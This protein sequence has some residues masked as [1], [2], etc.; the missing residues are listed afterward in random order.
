[1][2]CVRLRSVARTI[3][4]TGTSPSLSARITKEPPPRLRSSRSDDS[5]AAA[6]LDV[7]KVFTVTGV[8]VPPW[9][10][11]VAEMWADRVETGLV[12]LFAGHCSDLGGFSGARGEARLPMPERPVTVGDR[13]QADMRNVV[14]HCDR[15]IE[16]AVAEGLFEVGECEQ[17]FAQ[18]G[19]VRELEPAHAADAIRGLGALDRAG[20]D[21]GMPAV[22]A[23]EIA[24]HA[25]DCAG[26]R[27]EDSALDDV[28]HGVSLRTRA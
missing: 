28:R 3:V 16:Q 5:A 6:S 10:C 22:M 2:R 15:R 8:G 17:L 4:E 21:R 11:G 7:A 18:F 24:Q 12:D 1:S 25:P 14:E 13:Q 20:C 23:V 26:R 27:I 19:A 9:S